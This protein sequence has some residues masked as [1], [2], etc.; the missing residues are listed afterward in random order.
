MIP[1]L[2]IACLLGLASCRCEPTAR[3]AATKHQTPQSA[4]TNGDHSDAKGTASAESTAETSLP[5]TFDDLS[6]DQ[7]SEVERI[8]LEFADCFIVLQESH[9]G[10]FPLHL[11][12]WDFIEEACGLSK[13]AR[14]PRKA[15]TGDRSFSICM[16]NPW[17]LEPF[18]GFSGP[19]TPGEPQGQDRW[20]VVHLVPR[21]LGYTRTAVLHSDGSIQWLTP[22]EYEAALRPQWERL[23]QWLDSLE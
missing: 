16:S 23:D 9:G 3:T 8:L 17:T 11:N 21:V 14:W 12:S 15:P 6:A 10:H 22:A 19:E 5:Q 4:S 1:R 13:E 18:R 20:I 2:T 7:R